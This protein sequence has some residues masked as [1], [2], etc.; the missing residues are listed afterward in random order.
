MTGSNLLFAIPAFRAARRP[1]VV[2]DATCHLGHTRRM[3]SH[4]VLCKASV[5]S[6]GLGTRKQARALA[7]QLLAVTS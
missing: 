6:N 3:C 4:Y 7:Y 2:T 5:C 1:A